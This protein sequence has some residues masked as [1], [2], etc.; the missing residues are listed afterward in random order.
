MKAQRI[1]LSGLFL[2]ACLTAACGDG[3]DDGSSKGTLVVPFTL[4]NSRPCDVLGVKN[5]RAELND[6]S[7]V[8][9][10]P[11]TAGQVR[12]VGIPSGTYKIDLY[13]VDDTGVEIMDSTSEGDVSVNVI[14]NDQTTRRQPPVT[15]TAAPAHL[16]VRWDFKFSS[17]KGAHIQTFDIKAWRGSGDTLLLSKMLDCTSDGDG[18]DGYHEIEDPERRLTGDDSGEVSVQPYDMN[19]AEIGGPV[20]FKFRAPGSGYDVKVTVEC[21]AAG[22][23]GG[24][25]KPD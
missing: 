22:F 24:S 14:G 6:S 8:Q 3:D 18:P 21:D 11:C 1:V 13:G 17:C 15:L 16:F 20:V 25:G 23:C 9:T 7:F 5:V 10:A 2:I 12:F 4:G 19:K